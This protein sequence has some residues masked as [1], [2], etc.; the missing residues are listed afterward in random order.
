[1]EGGILHFLGYLSL[2]C[3]LCNSYPG[4]KHKHHKWG[5][6]IRTQ[7]LKTNNP[8]PSAGSKVLLWNWRTPQK[9][10]DTPWIWSRYSFSRL[11]H[12]LLYSSEQNPSPCTCNSQHTPGHVWEIH[13][14]QKISGCVWKYNH[15]KF[16]SIQKFEHPKYSRHSIRLLVSN[17]ETTLV[18]TQLVKIL[19]H[20]LV[21]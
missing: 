6:S 10:G 16:P 8:T 21:E 9:R 11:W 7:D 4:W 14:S 20:L 15:Q 19:S 1:M 12:R 13:Y 5:T 3:L 17:M 2:P 18:Q